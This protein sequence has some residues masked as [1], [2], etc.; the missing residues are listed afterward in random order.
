MKHDVKFF[1]QHL[2]TF[3]SSCFNDKCC[4]LTFSR[5]KWKV[6]KI[7]GCKKK[8]RGKLQENSTWAVIKIVF[9]AHEHHY[10]QT[11]S[12][13]PLFNF[14]VFKGLSRW[15]PDFLHAGICGVFYKRCNVIYCYSLQMIPQSESQAKR[16]EEENTRG[17]KSFSEVK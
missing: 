16:K 1:P 15:L 3:P 4:S 14:S 9:S 10:A 6:K 11:F 5:F 8:K 17:E 12:I 2:T 7:V 13:F